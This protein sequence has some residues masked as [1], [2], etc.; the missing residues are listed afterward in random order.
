M[1]VAILVEFELILISLKELSFVTLF[2]FSCRNGDKSCKPNAKGKLKCQLCR[3]NKCVKVG[4]IP[5]LVGCNKG[6]KS[7]EVKMIKAELK[8]KLNKKKRVV[9]RRNNNCGDRPSNNVIADALMNYLNILQEGLLKIL[10]ALSLFLGHLPHLG[11]V[12]GTITFKYCF[13]LIRALG[14]ITLGGRFT[15]GPLICIVDPRR[16]Y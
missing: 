8:L 2:F 9:T 3:Y 14:I 16:T 4:M 13:Q 6:N 5:E 15:K 7:E 1:D 11:I 10:M 12:K